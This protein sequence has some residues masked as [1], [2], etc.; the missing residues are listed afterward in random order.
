MNNYENPYIRL[1]TYYS[2]ISRGSYDL[3]G[4]SILELHHYTQIPIDT[5]RLDIA[6]ILKW[7]AAINSKYDGDISFIPENLENRI[8]LDFENI[9]DLFKENQSD[10]DMSDEDSQFE[11]TIA[12]MLNRFDPDLEEKLLNGGFDHIPIDIENCSL[13]ESDNFNIALSYDESLALDAIRK[14]IT[15]DKPSPITKTSFLQIKDSYRTIHDYQ[16]LTSRLQIIDEAIKKKKSLS[17]NYKNSIG[18]I[19]KITFQ[20]LK[21][22]YD[23]SENLYCVLSVSE[24]KIQVHRLDRILDLRPGTEKV[25]AGDSS[26]ID[27]IAPQVWGNCFS[28]QPEHVKVK[29]YNEANVWEK[30]KRDL[31]C[32]TKGH[33]YEKDGY[34]YYEDTVYGISKFRPWI[35]GFGSSAIVQEPKSLREHIIKSLKERKNR[36]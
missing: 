7:Q 16:E 23:E 22:S 20:P 13:T 15:P 19:L 27:S 35:Y 32:R 3:D 8:F 12:D 34:L 30:V 6:A 36:G 4:M 21:I 25:D 2:W 9:K 24:N 11:Y 33:L 31:A 10:G 17:M 14:D 28:E 18:E 5:I 29:F 26:I 1:Q